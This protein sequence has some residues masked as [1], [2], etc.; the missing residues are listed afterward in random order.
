[1]LARRM[2]ILIGIFYITKYNGALVIVVL[3][4]VESRKTWHYIQ[5][6]HSQT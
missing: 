3:L 2:R 5:W 1:M 6:S 4:L